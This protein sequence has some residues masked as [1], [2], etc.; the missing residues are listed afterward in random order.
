MIISQKKQTI[1]NPEDISNMFKAIIASEHITD[2]DKEHF[3][4][5]GLSG[6]S[7]I[8]YIEL[9]SLGILDSAVIHPRE[10][11]RYSIMM[12]C[13]KIVLVHNHPGGSVTPSKEDELVTKKLVAASEIIGIKVLDH[14]I[15]GED[16]YYSFLSEG[17]LDS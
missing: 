5:V 3:W 15:I 13:A 14:I 4:V 9:V 16:S 7:V 2:Q 1:H 17:R 11:F 8:L 6:R 12:A 10:V